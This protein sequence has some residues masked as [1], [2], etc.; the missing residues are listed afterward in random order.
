MR[1]M[2]TTVVWLGALAFVAGPATVVRAATD[3]P[4]TVVAH[5][6]LSP[7]LHE[8]TV[9]SPALERE[10][11]VRVQVP[12][13]HADDPDRRWP[14]ALLLH[15]RSENATTWSDRTDLERFDGMVLVMP[16][17]GQVGWYTDW[18]DDSCCGAQEW[19]SFHLGEVLPW[20]TATFRAHDERSQRFVAGVSMGGFGAMSYAARHPD[21]FG[22]A[23][24]FSGFVDLML[25]EVSGLVGVDGESFRVAG[26]PPGSV[27]GPVVSEELR[28]RGHNPVDLAPNLAWTDLVLRHGNGLPG[29]FGGDPDAGEA[30]IRLT[31]ISFHERLVE[32]GID[33]QWDDYGD[34]V[35]TWPYWEW[36]LEVT[37]PR[38]RQVAE[39]AA[40]D[41]VPFSYRTIEPRFDVYGWEVAIERE[42]LEFAELADVSPDGFTLT[43]SGQAQVTS[44]PW[45]AAG[46][47]HLVATGDA[48][49]VAIVAD[50]A[51]RLAVD[52]DLGP[53][54]PAQ[55]YTV[56]ADVR[57]AAGQAIRTT[58]PVT[59]E[60]A[61][62]I[63][64]P[65]DP[66]PGSASAPG[67]QARPPLPATGQPG[68]AVALAVL[69][70]TASLA[71]AFRGGR[72]PE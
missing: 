8:F 49:P 4:L 17:G 22:G 59:I 50:A 34:G 57:E 2:A 36:G 51:G 60:V 41:P 55:Q 24:E 47:T 6:Q 42:A 38:W 71:L 64:G 20:A 21:L 30:A 67:W 14:L 3:P 18:F 35:H 68:V 70:L 45:F 58:V 12:T 10:A 1:R 72:M 26:T 15:G 16:E 5:E 32:L 46:T 54:N 27:F 56:E 48:P 52:V 43:G 11:L 53:S 33:H 65:R 63:A 7:R 44:A 62:E 31:G 28:W 29:Q 61:A 23:A 40:P 9:A 25:L 39:A 13:G 37:W 69:L 66:G 19:E